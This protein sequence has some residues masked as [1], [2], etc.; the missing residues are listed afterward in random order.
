SAYVD[1]ENN[2]YGIVREMRSPQDEINKRRSKALHLL[3][4]RQILADRGAVESV[5][6]V[7]AE[8]AKPDGYIEKNPQMNLE[9][10]QTGDLT[11]G[12]FQLLQEAKGE[13]DMMGPN[14]AMEGRGGADQSGRAILAQQQ[15]GYI[16]LGQLT[17][18]LRQMSLLVYRAVWNRIRQYWNEE[19]WIRVTDNENNLKFVGLNRPVSA[20]EVELQKLQ[21]SGLAPQELEH[22]KQQI[23]SDPA[24]SEIIRYENT[25]GDL[26]VDIILEEV[27]DTV[28][29]RHEQFR[30]LT[31]LAASGIPIPPDVLIEASSLRNKKE[32]LQKL[33]GSQ[34]DPM[35]QKMME[36]ELAEKEAEIQK[37]RA[38]AEKKQAEAAVKQIDAGLVPADGSVQQTSMPEVSQHAPQQT[39]AKS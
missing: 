37:L 29:I 31:S 9:I 18:R 6:R 10:L 12:H 2:R 25:V 27:P 34:P 13:I 22:L 11:G 5:R 4:T 30:E 16:E 36:L 26:D 15:S 24:M 23:Q 32:L 3:S 33:Q 35:Q 14:P 28:T 21:D 17:D 38:D 7:K 19:R 39:I 20:G 1:R 8:L